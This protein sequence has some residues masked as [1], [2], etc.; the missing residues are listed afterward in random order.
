MLAGPEAKSGQ[1]CPMV[2][3]SWRAWKPKR[4][5]IGSNDA[6]AQAVLEG[7]DA[8]TAQDGTVRSML[9]RCR[10]PSN[11]LATYLESC[12]QTPEVATMLCR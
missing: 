8:N 5:A 7:E 4:K 6:E 3:L 10:G 9:T 2:L 12:A 11:K 1:V